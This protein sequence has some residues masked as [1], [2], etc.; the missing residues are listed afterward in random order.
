MQVFPVVD[1][2][3]HAGPGQL[4]VRVCVIEPTCPAGHDWIR[5]SGLRG[6]HCES[7]GVHDCMTGGLL[8][9]QRFSGTFAYA[10]EIHETL[11]DCVLLRQLDH[12]P[13]FQKYVG[14]Y[15]FPPPEPPPPLAGGGCTGG[16]PMGVVMFPGGV[17]ES[18]AQFLSAARVRTPVKPTGSRLLARWKFCTAPSV[19]APKNP[20]AES[21]VRRF[22]ETR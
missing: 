6:I 12:M 8:E 4:L 10:D 13:V 16:I 19:S 18:G 11:R 5:V 7:D 21:A 2:S 17:I 15:M 20:V 14:V 3:L 22:C 9:V 1:H